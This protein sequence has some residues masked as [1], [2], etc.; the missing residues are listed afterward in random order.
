[1]RMMTTEGFALGR[2]HNLLD[3]LIGVVVWLGRFSG[4]RRLTARTFT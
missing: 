4:S 2:E 3:I 1:M